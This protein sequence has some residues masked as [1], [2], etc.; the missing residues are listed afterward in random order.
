MASMEPNSVVIPL[1]LQWGVCM[2]ACVHEHVHLCVYVCVGACTH[3]LVPTVESVVWICEWVSICVCMLM[4]Y[5]AVSGCVR[6]CVPIYLFSQLSLHLNMGYQNTLVF[7]TLW[8]GTCIPGITLHTYLCEPG[9][10]HWIH[11]IQEC[12]GI[13]QVQL[14]SDQVTL[15]RNIFQVENSPSGLI[16]HKSLKS[17]SR[18]QNQQV[19]NLWPERDLL[20]H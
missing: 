19:G 5:M 1:R 11:I 10:S 6:A 9:W 13:F 16:T 12:E 7:W 20:W 17:G 18:D 15:C 8:A 3:K 4:V 2:H 14:R